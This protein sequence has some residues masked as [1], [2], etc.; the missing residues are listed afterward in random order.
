MASWWRKLTQIGVHAGVSTIDRQRIAFMNFLAVLGIALTLLSIP[1]AVIDQNWIALPTSLVVSAL[2]T[3]VLGLNQRGWY[4]GAAAYFFSL[5]V[6]ATVF[7]ILALQSDSG[8]HYWLLAM[9]IMPLLS[10]PAQHNRTALLAALIAIGIFLWISATFALDLTQVDL[11]SVLFS[12]FSVSLGLIAVSYYYRLAIQSAYRQM[13]QAQA[14][15]DR[16]LLNILP[17][18]IAERLK[19]TPG[20]I[21]DRFENTTVLFADLVAFTPLAERLEPEATVR[22]LNDLFS[23][24]DEII[25]RYGL[26]KIKTVGDG[27]VAVA[28]LP[29]PNPRH[30]HLA[31]EAALE[32]QTALQRFNLSHK[33]Q[34]ELRVGLHSGPVVAGVIGQRKFVYDLWGD[35]VN[36]AARMESHGLAGKIQITEASRQLLQGA[37]EITTRGTIPVKG[38]SDMSVYWL[39]RPIPPA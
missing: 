9:I 22:L 6:G 25:G 35:V 19:H 4:L 38:K 24:F 26:E 30:A 8:L 21:A 17:A 31:A 2:F 3:L 15:S 29:E 23:V 10:F 34:L 27:Y 16:L 1:V 36:V 37:F 32:M 20:V 5:S 7:Q 28:G 12:R 18:K 33:Y 13:E 11:A 39:S 14:E